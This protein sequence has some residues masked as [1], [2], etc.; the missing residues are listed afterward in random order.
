MLNESEGLSQSLD[1]RAY[2]P[3]PIQSALSMSAWLLR[4]HHC[5][6][7]STTSLQGR[8]DPHL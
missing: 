7:Y 2:S 4:P 6:S 5:Q 1:I 3:C 8:M